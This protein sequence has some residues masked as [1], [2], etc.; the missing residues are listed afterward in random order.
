MSLKDITFNHFK[1]HTQ[2]SIC[3][4]AVKI[5][6]L[7]KYA[8]LTKF[9]S[10]GI[11]DSYNLSGALEFSEDLA[12]VGVHPIIGAQLNIKTE[13]V[14]G[15]VSLIAKNEQGYKNLLKLSSKSYLDIN[16]TDAPHCSIKDLLDYS[17]GLFILLGGNNTLTSKLILNN[18]DKIFLNNVNKI[19]SAFK[20]NLFFEIQR[21]NE[22][23][24]DRIENFLVSNARSF[25]I[26]IIASQEVFYIHQDMYEAH[27]AYIC[28]G[29]KAY[30]EDKNRI[31]YSDQHY[32]KSNEEMLKLFADLPDALE[33]N[34]NIRYQC[35]YR[36]LPSKPLLPNFIS[37]AENNI[38]KVLQD[39][40]LK[41][42]DRRLNEVVLKNITD[43]N[44]IED[45][46]KIYLERLNYEVKMI[47]Q[48][49]FSGYFLIVSDYILWAKN[50]NIP[51][52]PGRGSGAGSLVAWALSITEL[53]PIKFGLIFERFLNPD[54]ISIPDFDI[55]FCQEDRDKVINYVKNKYKGGVAQIITFGK[56][57][58]RM[59]IRDIGRVIGLPY[60][61]VDSLSKMIPFDPSRPL[62]LQESVALEPRIQEAQKNDPKIDKLIKLAIKLEGLY[63]NIATHAAGIVIAD[64]QI[65]EVVPLY[66]DFGSENDIPV[67]QFDMKWSENAG[68]VKFD[69][70]GLK[71][72]TV[73]KKT[74]NSL[75]ENNINVNLKDLPLDDPKTFELL[76]SGET[77]GVFQLESSGMRE[78]L[79][80]MKPN[81]FEDIIALVALFRP[82]PMQN[83]SKYN[84]CKHGIEKPDYL[85]P[86]IEHIL[87][88]TYGV[89]IYQEQVM[90]IAQSLSGF[91]AGKADILR[92]AMGK[93]KSAEM[94][95]Q[96]KDFIEG[97]VKNGI[98]KDQAVY[99][100][101]LVEKFAQYGFNKSHAAAYALIA[102]QTAYLKTHYP[103]YF[104]SA[105][106]NL[107][108][109]NT[110]KLNEFYEELKRLKIDV[111]LPSINESYADFVVKQ[112]KVYYALSAIKA[113][114]YESVNQII[115]DRNKNGQFKSLEDFILR[116]DSKLINKLQMEGLIKSGAFDCLEKNRKFLFDA[117]PEIIK[118]SKNYK[119]SNLLQDNLFGNDKNSHL[120]SLEN[121]VSKNETWN[122]NEKM[123]NE[124]ES[125]GF[126]IS[127]HPLL[128]YEK[129]L[130]VYNVKR[131]ADISEHDLN[132]EFVLSGTLMAIQEK[133]TAKGQPF[134]IIK[135]SDLSRMYELFIFSETLL[136]NRDK[137]IPGNSF[138]ANI[139]K[140]KMT[141]GTTRLTV[142]KLTEIN[143]I[144]EAKINKAEII[145]KDLG[146]INELKKILKDNG[147]TKVSIR[148]NSKD[149]N[150]VFNL[151]NNKLIDASIVSVLNSSGFECKIH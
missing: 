55:D 24:E 130:K 25:K 109:A 73:I 10:L 49:K 133:K 65:E 11:S 6:D 146:S 78:V 52:G 82:G 142:R 69:F 54:R 53:D 12:K 22:A 28:I 20:D 105:S 139:I 18:Q 134:A 103:L 30:V 143:S 116:I 120:P 144:K 7:A 44:Q 51:V 76:C 131:F 87:K 13:N 45:T 92:K 107:D 136:A 114:G 106:M 121:L 50:N 148:M 29:Q 90:Q 108:L 23:N 128:N 149:K 124:F 59:A 40:A 47:N 5:E 3:E 127:E 36:P 43:L 86:K 60:S 27:D 137:L 129:V 19:K 135:L 110:D 102:Y 141:N 42:L 41:G 123:K 77:M 75:K 2:Y 48:M 126:F 98:T 81:K 46:K 99:I 96:K 33:N 111:I 21:H 101:Q 61:V 31:S 35:L 115:L 125:I 119:E 71:T 150:Y 104:V 1:I 39:L 88:E 85:H 117:V 32:L 83:I 79:K 93:K 17:S 122:Q 113:V 95:R 84:N 140:E 14:I 89:I 94:E 63:R 67:T 15:K 8:K 118:I 70:L 56:L 145:I 151:K 68:L 4:G 37:G 80:Q 64:R 74:I 100:F 66:K 97:A 58:A 62:S 9:L 72:L 16:A 38:E 34:N 57:Q 147:D 138:L 112:N 26:P 91:S 132:K